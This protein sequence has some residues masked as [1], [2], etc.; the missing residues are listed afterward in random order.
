MKID[1]KK[2]WSVVRPIL[3]VLTDL[4]NKGREAGL[5]TKKNGIPT[6]R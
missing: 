6:K 3:T 4:L 5:W 1:L 2:A